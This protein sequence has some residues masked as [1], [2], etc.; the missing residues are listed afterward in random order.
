MDG[1]LTRFQTASSLSFALNIRGRTQ[2]LSEL[3]RYSMG[4]RPSGEAVRPVFPSDFRAKEILFTVYCKYNQCPVV[5]KLLNANL[6]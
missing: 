3:A 6:G 5:Q 1:S 4:E 2:T